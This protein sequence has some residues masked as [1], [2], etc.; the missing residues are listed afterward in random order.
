MLGQATA[1]G[2]GSLA[3]RG[4]PMKTQWGIPIAWHDRTEY[5]GTDAWS[6]DRWRWE[7]TRRREDYRADYE[8]LLPETLRWIEALRK[9]DPELIYP[10]P[11]DVEFG[12]FGD[13]TTKGTY[14]LLSLPNPR[15][16]D[17]KYF[18]F[19][20]SDGGDILI[21]D[22][23]PGT[24]HEPETLDVPLGYAAV[25]IDLSLPLDRQWE[26]AR[27]MVAMYQSEQIGRV[28]AN[29]KHATKWLGYLQVLDAREQGA[30]LRQIAESG[31]LGG[32]RRSASSVDQRDQVAKQVW[33]QARRLMFNWP[34]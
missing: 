10:T 6:D 25:L 28:S 34:R 30:T 20:N 11:D 27:D 33:D 21:G 12:V 19:M 17:A 31:V 8:R 9:T 3:A 1:I 18:F 22:G 29:R 16:S 5:G 13:L 24:S 4:F 14:G 32:A 23:G 15:L 26:S 2:I 7:F